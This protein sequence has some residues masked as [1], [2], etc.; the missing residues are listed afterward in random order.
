MPHKY[1]LVRGNWVAKRRSQAEVYH[2]SFVQVSA[3]PFSL[4]QDRDGIVANLSQR[5]PISGS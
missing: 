3:G 5:W 2:Q 1:N 4:P